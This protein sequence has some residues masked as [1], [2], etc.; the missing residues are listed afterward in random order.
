MSSRVETR[1]YVW[2]YGSR[3]G[4][5]AEFGDAIIYSATPLSIQDTVELGKR[6]GNW[7][8]PNASRHEKRG[9]KLVVPRF[10]TWIAGDLDKVPPQ[11]LY[12]VRLIQVGPWLRAEWKASS[13]VPSSSIVTLPEDLSKNTVDKYVSSS[14]S[15]ICSEFFESVV[16]NPVCRGGFR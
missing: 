10:S 13:R 14:T 1:Q 4:K 12:D 16:V 9:K 2:W 11:V 8:A 7:P 15:K 5:G 6:N 3:R